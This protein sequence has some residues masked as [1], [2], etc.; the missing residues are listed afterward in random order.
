MITRIQTDARWLALPLFGVIL[1]AS[2]AFGCRA[3]AHSKDLES[4]SVTLERTAC[5]GTCPVYIVTIHGNGLVEYVGRLHVDIPGYQRASIQP[6]S[7][8]DLLKAF[9]TNHFTSLK[10]SYLGPCEDVPT[11]IISLESDGKAKRVATNSCE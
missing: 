7:F 4:V 5:Y 3:P 8:N 1:S 9:E 2:L 11:A 6:G 10:E